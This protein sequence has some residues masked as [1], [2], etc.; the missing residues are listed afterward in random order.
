M[1]QRTDEFWDDFLEENA[2]AEAAGTQDNFAEK[3]ANLEKNISDR[4]DEV[5]KSLIN[6][7]QEEAKK[8]NYLD[9]L[10]NTEQDPAYSEEEGEEENEENE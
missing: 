1:L 5:E 7:L 9:P 4:I 2:A 6:T 8:P 3:M 10:K